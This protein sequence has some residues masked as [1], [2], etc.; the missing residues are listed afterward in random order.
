MQSEDDTLNRG[1]YLH[2]RDMIMTWRYLILVLLL[3][4]RLPVL[5]FFSTRSSHPLA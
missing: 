1:N 4:V 2:N 3:V 5:S